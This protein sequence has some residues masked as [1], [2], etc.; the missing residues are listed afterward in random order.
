MK[1][2]HVVM[3]FKRHQ[4][5]QNLIDY[6]SKTNTILYPLTFVDE[7]PMDAIADWIRPFVTQRQEAVFPCAKLINLFIKT[8]NIVNDEYYVQANDDE[9]YEDGVFK[10]I[11]EYDD[12]V[13]VIS[14][15][16][17]HHIPTKSECPPYLT[18]TIMG[19][20]NNMFVGQIGGEQV[21]IKGRIFKTLNF[22]E[23]DVCRDGII[24]EEL[25]HKYRIRY[26]PNLYCLFNYFEPGRW[27]N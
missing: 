24:A 19:D 2:V 21:F 26:E 12:D 7:K 18:T 13:V 8:A 10:Q 3:P 9:I 5:T 23:T 4:H 6:Y 25:K 17:G 15:K 27:D 14:M 16:R 11:S 20:P 22:S 1:N